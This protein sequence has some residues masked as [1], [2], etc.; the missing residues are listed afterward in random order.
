MAG[1]AAA[2][3]GAMGRGETV[4]TSAASLDSWL[5]TVDISGAKP[6]KYNILVTATDLAGNQALAG[7][8]NLYVDPDSDLPVT[9]ITNPLDG[10][11][12]P[13]NLNV[14][15]TCL[16]DDA[17]DHVELIFD[18]GDPIRAQGKEFWSY[19]L[20]TNGL[21]EGPHIISAYGVDVNGTAGKPFTAV[22]HLD[23]QQPE[24]AVSNVG[25]GTLVSGKVS[26]TGTVNDGN[27]IKRLAYSLDDGKTF[28]ALSIKFDKK[29]RDW[30]FTLPLNTLKFPDGPAV[31]WFRAEDDQGSIGLY[32]FLYF[33]DNTKPS[34]SFISPLTDVAVNGKFSVSGLATDT[35][36]ID[37]LS[38]RLGKETGNFELVKGNPYWIRE[39]DAS[40]QGGKN[41]EV[42]ITAKDIAGNATTVSRKIPIDRAADVPRLSLTSPAPDSTFPS[43]VWLSGSVTDDDGA[44]AV[45]FSIDKGERKDLETAGAFGAKL[46]GLTAGKHSATFWPVDINGLEGA[47]VTVGFFV[48]GP[49]PAISFTPVDDPA[50]EISAEEGA[51][52]SARVESPAGLKALSWRIA[53]MP[54]QTVKLKP[55]ETSRDLTIPVTPDVP[56][57]L[58]RLEVTAVDVFDRT[59]TSGTEFYVTNLS[60]PRDAPPAWS[61][62]TLTASGTVTIPASG[63]TP[64]GTGTATAT[65]ERLLPADVPFA[66]G[67]L[68]T[69][70]G[71]AFPKAEQVDGAAV[72]GIDSPIPVSSVEWSLNGGE[73]AKA[74]VQKTA[75][76]RYE[77]SIPLKAL[78]PADWTTLSINVILKDMTSLG[79]SGT[80]CV[81]RPEPAAGLNDGEGF[82]WDSPRLDGSGKILLYDGAAASGLYNGKP[83]RKAA[84]AKFSAPVPGLELSL[85]GNVATVR[86]LKDGTYTDVRI[87]FTD[88]AGGEWESA[89][90]TFAVDSGAPAL[91]VDTSTRPVWLQGTLPVT[92]GATDAAGIARVE[93]SLD[94]GA[95]WTPVEKPDGSTLTM[96]DISAL[97][98]GPVDF[99]VRAV[100]ANGRETAERRAFNKDTTPPAVSVIVP[101]PGD[102]VNGETRIAFEPADASP[103]VSAE[104]RGPGDRTDK[105][106]TQWV[107][108]ELA[109]A[110][111]TLVGTA[112]KPLDPGMEFRFTDAAGNRAVLG[113]WLFSI[114]P[115][116]DLPAV[117]IHLPADNEVIRKDFA[118]SGVVYDDDAPARIWY[119]ID[120]GPYAAFD[121][122]NSYSIPIPLSSLTDNEHVITLYAEDIHGVK[123]AEISR[124]VRVSLEEPK[125]A[126]LTPSFETTNRGV[127]DVTGNASD[128]NGIEKVEISLDNGNSFGL[129]EGTEEW[130]YRFDSRVIED[131]THVVFV[132]VYDAYG[133]TG[134]YSSLI[135]IDNTSPSINLELPL[136]GSRVANTLFISGQT[137]DNIKLARVTA[138]ISGLDA[139]RPEMPK[140]FDDIG[141]DDSLII[142]G[143]IDVS[144]L[145][146]GFYNVEVRGYDLAGNVTRVSRNFEVYRGADRNRIEFLYPLNGEGV[147]GMFNAY[148][149]VVSEDPVGSLVL[150]VDGKES[151]TAELSPSGYFKFTVTPE[152]LA[153]GPH[154]LMVRALASGESVISSETHTVRYAAS[155]PW[156]TIDNLAMGDFAI[157]RPW[158]EGTAGYA[159][160]EE[161]VFALKAKNTPKDERRAL[162]DKTPDRVEISF[163]NGKTFFRTESG[164]KWRY[165]LETGELAEGY[166]FILVRATMKNGEVA[167][168]RSIVQVDKTLPTIRLISPGEG[169]RYNDALTFSGLSSDDV[170]LEA[171]DI[172]LRPGDKSSYALPSFIQGLYFDWHFWGATLYDV[173]LGLTFFDDNVKVQAQYG[174][175]TDAQRAIFTEGA[176]RYGGDVVGIKML[177]NVAYVPLDFFF[178]P[179]FSWLSATGAIG[180]N[181]SVFTETQSGTPQILSAMLV[182]FEFPR[183][184]IPKRTT[185]KTFSAYTEGQLWFIPTDVSSTEVSINS[186]IPHVTAGIRVSVF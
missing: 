155:G 146:E 112:D 110:I 105:D 169:G 127:I 75:E 1:F 30:R 149:R 128:R 159:L 108:L 51:S 134:L 26:L 62:D 15:G 119:K 135:N 67:A 178:G 91:T 171:V 18:G 34:V 78:L 157:D 97:P 120:D 111:T 71:P 164:R 70:S 7:P 54:E 73:T 174:Q 84:S 160:T 129:A 98:D 14:V 69:L 20:D 142:S 87:V 35:N 122:E 63:K 61:D 13:G 53:G 133:I 168:T 9:R 85:S 60:V 173:G 6:G 41:L 137:I 21:S 121:I 89:G 96:V 2:S 172:E 45:R 31:C 136:D 92:A 5:E 145:G 116:S 46:E 42:F 77:A 58:D 29:R 103:V 44:A 153:D 28:T 68:V 161:D 115:E 132:R 177:A 144:A 56:Y 32:T 17:V 181:F 118:V 167:V 158:L 130:S 150:F 48:T 82:E 182:Q 101:E 93:Y 184:T 113:S 72:V 152:T 123:G 162:Q 22:W 124:T 10:M 8:Y 59:V 19:Y 154:A 90:E 39:F 104:Y 49:E 163:D 107:P 40:G 176:A 36:G 43:A 126:V 37:T 99:T 66:N 117:E 88:D 185:F 64:A 16:D 114:E 57:G 186:V 83:D 11:R 80:F 179:D 165:R 55:G 79:V 47:P 81:I 95:R 74:S 166:H 4:K 76:G 156:V 109:S 140:G 33:V 65:L 86:G 175:F 147:Q 24:T 139:K 106:E 94:A 151:G 141:F 100:D 170:R 38:W 52:L 183:V 3:L 50:R 148:G 27:G 25:M 180:A 12:V 23:R 125:A 143:G 138:G 102:A 131:G